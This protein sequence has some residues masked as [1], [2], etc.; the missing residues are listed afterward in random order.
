MHWKVAAS[1]AAFTLV[2]AV[3]TASAATKWSPVT[4]G[5]QSNSA[6]LG[7]ARTADGVL[8]VAWD[9]DDP[10]TESINVTS[11]SPAGKIGATASVVSGWAGTGSPALVTTPTGDLRIFF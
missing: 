10:T 11:I 7:L 9:V 4:S 8:H 3:P 6:V 1:L 5:K 2:A